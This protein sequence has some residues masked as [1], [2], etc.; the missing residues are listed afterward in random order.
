V[1]QPDKALLAGLPPDETDRGTVDWVVVRLVKTSRE[2]GYTIEQAEVRT[3]SMLRM[4]AI[5]WG[6]EVPELSVS[7][8]VPDEPTQA[9]A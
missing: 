5:A 2:A 4:L 6:M 1:Y 8:R 9:P 3:V 7:A